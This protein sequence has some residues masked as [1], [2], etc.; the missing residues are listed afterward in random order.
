MSSEQ[1]SCAQRIDEHLAGREEDMLNIFNAMDN[2]EEYED[3]D[4][5]DAIHEYALG[6]EQKNML[7]IELSTGGPGDWL[8]CYLSDNFSVYKVEYHF[9]DWFDHAQTTVDEDSSLFRY[10][11]FIIDGMYFN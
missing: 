8:E 5:Y 11:E 9:N 2:E 4:A 7:K 6:Y 3:Q 1:L 10:A